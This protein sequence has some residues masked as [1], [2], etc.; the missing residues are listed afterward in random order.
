MGRF[1]AEHITG[2]TYVELA[3]E[4]QWPWAG[5]AD[6]VLDEVEEFLTGVRRGPDSDRVLATI[7]FTDIVGST[8][9]A[10]RMGDRNWRRLLD[11]HDRT[12]RDQFKRFGGREVNTTGDGFIAAFDGPARAV[13]CGTAIVDALGP[14][15]EVRVGVHTGECEARG[16]DLGGLAVHIAARVAASASP[17]TVFVSSTVRDLVAG[18]GISFRDLGNH[19]LRGVPGAWRLLAV[20]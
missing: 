1:L 2:A 20:E 6:S 7:L 11:D 4:D 19:E 13:R 5:D 12:V 15:L 17:G 3:G 9:Q 14:D 10:A 8:E 18:S 16:S